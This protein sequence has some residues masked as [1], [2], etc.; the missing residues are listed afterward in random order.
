MWLGPMVGSCVSI[1]SAAV[2]HP[3]NNEVVQPQHT[4]S[5]VHSHAQPI[6]KLTQAEN[7]TFTGFCII[8][9]GTDVLLLFFLS[10]YWG[11]KSTLTHICTHLSRSWFSICSLSSTCHQGPPSAWH[12]LWGAF[13]LTSSGEL[14][15]SNWCSLAA[16]TVCSNFHWWNLT[17][18]VTGVQPP[19]VVPLMP[20]GSFCLFSVLLDPLIW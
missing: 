13:W 12:V 7:R 8:R 3:L 17:N 19:I 10:S 14:Q 11:L 15:T 4:H 18:K 9:N 5:H 1:T 16:N 2:P 20:A 6:T